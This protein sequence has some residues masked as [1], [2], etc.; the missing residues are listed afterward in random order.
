MILLHVEDHTTWFEENVRPELEVFCSRVIHA[1][2]FELAKNIFDNTPI[3]YVILDQSI[4]LNDEDINP[5]IS[6]GLSFADYIKSNSPGTPILILTGQSR[7]EAVIRYVEEQP[8][9]FFF[10]GEFRGLIKVR[11]KRNLVD[12]L[13]IVRSYSESLEQLN[14][15]ELVSDVNLTEHETRVLKLF[16]KHRDCIGLRL[17]TIGGGLSGAKVYKVT[18]I[19]SAG[20]GVVNTLAKISDFESVDI[21]ANNYERH[22][23]ILAVGSYPTLLNTYYAGCSNVKGVFYQFAVD[24]SKNYFDLLVSDRGVAIEEIDRLLGI[25]SVWSSNK[26]T[27]TRQL[28]D[29]RRTICSDTK[30]EIART[31]FDF[32]FERVERKLVNYFECIQHGDLHGENILISQ[33]SSPIV[34]DY[35]DVK[36]TTSVLD[37]VTLEL[38]PFFHPSIKDKFGDL[39]MDIA[40]HW[41]DV[42]RVVEHSPFPDVS[43]FLGSLRQEY[44]LM[45]KDYAATVYSYAL[46][47]LSYPD[48]NREFAIQLVLSAVRKLN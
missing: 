41:F 7:D 16:G 21:D 36:L 9:T 24:Y 40:K 32:D 28:K 48:T 6:N 20:A 23:S 29:I 33:G 18:L 44:S 43:I 11:A 10:D 19:N 15:I 30:L 12:A 35:G 2:N 8:Q 34:I 1:S 27:V 39:S 4:P 5:T 25:L 31:F 45:G 22:I 46:R 3:D 42:Q 14:A 38:S 26:N 47:Q 13:S 17:K 37:L